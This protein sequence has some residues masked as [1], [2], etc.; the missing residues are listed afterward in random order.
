MPG[1]RKSSRKTQT[2]SQK[3]SITYQNKD[4]VSKIF[5]EQM[6]E[7]S[8]SAYGVKI[9]KIKEVL[10]T[11][12]PVVEANEL[13]LDNLFRLEDDSIALVDYE[14][15]YKY[16]HKIK[17]L[18]YIVRTL[19]KNDLIENIE[20]PLR[21]IV[22]YTGD[23]RKGTTNPSL[24]AG[25]LQFTVEEVF[26]SELDAD[27]IEGN[28]TRRILANETL[29]EEEQM[30]FVI[31]PLIY[32]G[33]E[34][35]QQC[36]RRC[37]ELAKRIES[38]HMQIFLLS[39]LLVFTDKVIAKEDSERIKR[40]I[41]MT[42]V[43]RLYEEE[44]Q[45]ALRQLEKKQQIEIKKLNNENRKKIQNLKK[46]Y[47]QTLQKTKKESAMQIARRLIEQGMPTAEIQR[48]I[49]NLSYDEIEKL[50]TDI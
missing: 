7:K 15:T 32:A 31:L 26:L 20:N 47:R 5:G 36:I 29:S 1:K 40:W 3:N 48:V 44:K 16:K 43:G 28:I 34:A 27:S 39:G 42:Q 11:N 10:P 18:N 25:C 38:F 12:L 9:P 33:K 14:S 46:E 8:L 45:E 24:D 17:Y 37:F 19:K 13:R 6:K 35:K 4:V 23:I 21:M 30:Q 2:N 22:I 41:N 50:K 49:T